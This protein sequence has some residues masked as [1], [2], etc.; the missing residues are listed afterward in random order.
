M[1]KRKTCFWVKV[2]VLGMRSF[3]NPSKLYADGCI[4]KTNDVLSECYNK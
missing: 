1:K 3:L 4:E 2:I